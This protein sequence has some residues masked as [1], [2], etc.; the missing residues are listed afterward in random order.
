MLWSA[1]A[2]VVSNARR[3]HRLPTCSSPCRR[4]TANSPA[5]T[6]GCAISISPDRYRHAVR[7]A[8]A[9]SRSDGRR[10][11][12]SGTERPICFSVIN[13]GE[14]ERG[15]ALQRPTDPGFSSALSEWLDRVLA[16]CGERIVP[17]DLPT[18][19]RWGALGAAL[20]NDSA[21]LMIAATALEHGLAVVTHNISYWS[22]TPAE[23]VSC[24]AGP[25]NTPIWI[26]RLHT[27]GSGSTTRCR[28]S[29]VA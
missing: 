7:A 25:R 6:C 26:S 22:A 19:R 24:S 20:G 10:K 28:T 18:A 23:R 27:R 9:S 5:I 12:S 17:F 2:C 4:M 14:I 16:L 15:I 8:Q 11:G 21:D 3:R 1:S 29:E 13:I